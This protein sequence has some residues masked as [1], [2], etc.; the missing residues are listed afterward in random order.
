M[1]L[2]NPLRL[3]FF[4]G[5]MF[6]FFT[7]SACSYLKPEKKILEKANL[8]KAAV[9]GPLGVAECD[10]Y[11]ARY[12]KCIDEKIPE[13][14]KK[15]YKEVIDETVKYWKTQTESPEEKMG[16]VSACNVAYLGSRKTLAA[17]GC[18]I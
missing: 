12:Q 6:C 7:F 10:D 5:A 4:V 3:K 8:G 1:N 13:R 17:F 2:L 16:L 14:S 15:A 18:E 11:I 9:A